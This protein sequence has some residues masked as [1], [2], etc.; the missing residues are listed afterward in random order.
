MS[1]MEDLENRVVL[2]NLI[3]AQ[4]LARL[5]PRDLP[6]NELIL[7]RC[8]IVTSECVGSVMDHWNLRIQCLQDPGRCLW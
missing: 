6:F 8:R 2:R 3:A 5:V 7:G 4:R 1:G